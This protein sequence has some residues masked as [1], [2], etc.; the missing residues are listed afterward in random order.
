MKKRS[1]LFV[2]GLAALFAG[3]CSSDDL[4][5]T[6]EGGQGTSPDGKAYV[7][8]N[9][10]MPV[11]GGSMSGRAEE[12]SSS[13]YGD[14]S[15]NEFAV[16]SISV[17]VFDQDTK[18]L[19]RV[20]SS[21]D[22][23]LAL[24]EW[25]TNSNSQITKTAKLPAFAV[26]DSNTKDLFVLLNYEDLSTLKALTLEGDLDKI[27]LSGDAN[28][29]ATAELGED[30]TITSGNGFLMCNAT[31]LNIGN[32][33]KTVQTLVSVKPQQ[34]K[35]AAENDENRCS[36]YVERLVGKVSLNHSQNGWSNWIYTIPNATLDGVNPSWAAG[37]KITV[38]GW[39][40]D[41]TN[42]KSYLVRQVE[43]D[44]FVD[45]YKYMNE[46]NRF[47]AVAPI[48]QN[49]NLYRIE[50][51]KDP[52]YTLSID[53]DKTKEFNYVSNFVNGGLDKALY[54]F[55]NTFDV[56]NQRQ[57]RTTRALIK[58][59]FQPKGFDENESWYTIGAS[60]QPRKGKVTVEIITQALKEIQGDVEVKVDVAKMSGTNDYQG[61]VTVGG[62]P[63][64]ESQINALKN[65][66]GDV[67]AYNQ[68]VCYYVIRVKHFG[69]VE[70]PWGSETNAP[71]VGENSD[72]Y[73]QYGNENNADNNENKYYLGRYGVVRNNWYSLN[74]NTISGPG[75][76]EIPTLGTDIDDEHSYYISADVNILSWRLRGQSEDL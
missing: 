75:A 60:E 3:A 26:E 69:D 8:L 74:I 48:V 72:P 54:C 40:L 14:G 23:T 73:W 66:I 32:S 10:S 21:L 36:I 55:E 76:P 46:T 1:C 44:W 71:K 70:T 24:P 43:S 4:A 25:T 52:N 11:S 27:V 9:I 50:W 37:A 57:D 15:N 39:E 68:G 65:K 7:S 12:E 13:I 49:G 58:A 64:S 31:L 22:N 33:E 28:Q 30:G 20:Y 16:K 41:V 6:D 18:K 56:Q 61:H 29:Y 35:T 34:T 5:L 45:T 67:K 19:E 63:I 17:V 51:A 62:S 42:K 47:Y 2:M 53:V 38:E 59:K